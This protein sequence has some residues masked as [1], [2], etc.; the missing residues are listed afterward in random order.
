MRTAAKRKTW[1]PKWLD[2]IN[3]RSLIVDRNHLQARY[4][5]AEIW[6]NEEDVLIGR[7]IIPLRDACGDAPVHFRARISSDDE[8][9]GYLAGYLHVQWADQE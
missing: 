8:T 4:L 9:K 7:G 1:E 2:S 6:D 5:I 3:L